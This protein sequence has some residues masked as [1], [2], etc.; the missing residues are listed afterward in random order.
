MLCDGLDGW[1]GGGTGREA[2]EGGDAYVYIY[3]YIYIFLSQFIAQQNIN[4]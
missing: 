1:D 2:Q 3:I 4:V